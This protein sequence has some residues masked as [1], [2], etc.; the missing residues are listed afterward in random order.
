MNLYEI[1]E[2]KFV[3]SN[4]GSTS[5][6]FAGFTAQRHN[7]I[8]R[9]RLVLKNGKWSFY[10][11]EKDKSKYVRL[12]EFVKLYRQGNIQSV[13]AYYEDGEPSM[14][15]LSTMISTLDFKAILDDLSIIAS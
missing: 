4:S 15:T 14:I 11:K 10:N 3:V 7:K 5:A 2:T 12:D 9:P 13:A 8:L 1:L 6:V